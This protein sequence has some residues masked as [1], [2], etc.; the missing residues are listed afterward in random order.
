MKT[1][2]TLLRFIFF[3]LAIDNGYSLYQVFQNSNYAI[4]TK[5]LLIVFRVAL[6]IF[7]IML[8]IKKNNNT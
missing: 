7:F 1:S 4:S 6:I 2:S 5:I 8:V 3:L